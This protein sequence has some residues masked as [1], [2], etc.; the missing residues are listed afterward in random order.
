M[1]DGVIGP[2]GLLVQG[3]VE[4]ALCRGQG[5]VTK[6]MDIALVWRKKWKAVTYKIA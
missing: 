2:I 5:I 1:G 6:L 3:L 4:R